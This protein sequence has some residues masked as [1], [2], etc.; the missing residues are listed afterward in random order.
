[1][2]LIIVINLGE[3]AGKLLQEEWPCAGTITP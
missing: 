1:M 2:Q 3:D